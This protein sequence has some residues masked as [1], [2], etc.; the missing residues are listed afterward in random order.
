MSSVVL[1][2]RCCELAE[3]VIKMRA[4]FDIIRELT[5]IPTTF[6]T[7]LSRI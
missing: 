7:N 5:E 1:D 3:F 4:V 6:R 2:L